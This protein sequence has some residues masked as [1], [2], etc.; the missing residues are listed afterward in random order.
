[1]NSIREKGYDLDGM[2]ERDYVAMHS[3]VFRMEAVFDEV[4]ASPESGTFYFFAS[5][6]AARNL[7]GGRIPGCKNW[8]EAKWGRTQIPC[9][10][11]CHSPS[12]LWHW[13]GDD[14]VLHH[15]DHEGDEKFVVGV[16]AR[17]AT[18]RARMRAKLEQAEN[19]RKPNDPK[20]TDPPPPKEKRASKAR[21][22]AV[23]GNRTNTNGADLRSGDSVA[24]HDP[25]SIEDDFN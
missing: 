11:A 18:T 8:S 1:M 3:P 5:F 15:Y 10:S 22:A 2:A 6:Y 24:G 13:E 17:R 14:L 23:E 25:K 16:L 19:L 7:T 9:S 12:V 4:E 20:E 21:G